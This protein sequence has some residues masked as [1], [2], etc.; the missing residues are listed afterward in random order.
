M[1]VHVT[2][3]INGDDVEFLCPPEQTLLDTL[4]DDLDLTGTKEG[5]GTGDCGACS[6]LVNGRPR[7]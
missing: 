7:T 3:T 1:K 6:V 4:R 5:C 2:T